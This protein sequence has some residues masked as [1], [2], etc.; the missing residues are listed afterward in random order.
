M[1]EGR[2][3]VDPKERGSGY[4]VL[5]AMVKQD[6][7]KGLIKDWGAFPGEGRGYVVVE[8]TY[9]EIMKK[10][11]DSVAKAQLAALDTHMEGVAQK[12]NVKPAKIEWDELEKEAAKLVPKPTAKVKMNGYRGYSQFISKVPK[13]E[14]DKYSF[15]RGDIASTSE[16][17]SLINGK[18]SVLDIKQSL[19]AQYQR[20]SKLESVFNYIQI[21]KLAGLVEF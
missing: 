16:L 11:I 2:T 19:D 8:G 6:I 9:L 4:G 17:Q 15:S 1:S 13:K 3:Q 20:K 18:R 12:L 10:T 14:A 21:L 7:E 5:M